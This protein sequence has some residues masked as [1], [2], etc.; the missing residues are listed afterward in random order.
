MNNNYCFCIFQ[1]NLWLDY[2][3]T[4]LTHHS[5]YICMENRTLYA[6]NHLV[7]PALLEYEIP[8]EYSVRILY[9][10]RCLVNKN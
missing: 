4:N 3:P 6:P 1:T 10:N 7:R 5:I 9:E 8:S 2:D